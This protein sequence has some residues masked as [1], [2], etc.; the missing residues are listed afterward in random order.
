MSENESSDRDLEQRLRNFYDQTFGQPPDIDKLWQTLAPNLGAQRQPSVR[1]RVRKWLAMPAKLTRARAVVLAMLCLILGLALAFSPAGQAAAH[2]AGNLQPVQGSPSTATPSPLPADSVW[3]IDPENGELNSALLSVDPVSGQILRVL[4]TRYTPDSVLSPDYKRLY[5]VDTYYTRGN[6]GDSISALTVYDAESGMILHD[7]IQVPERLMYKMYPTFRTLFISP[8]GST[9]YLL[10]Y[11]KNGDNNAVR[12]VALDTVR[13][14]QLWE[15]TLT[16]CDT[17]Q[18]LSDNVKPIVYAICPEGK[19]VALG[20]GTG[21]VQSTLKIPSK[22]GQ[23]VNVIASVE[24]RK[25]LIVATADGHLYGLEMSGDHQNLVSDH[26]I[27]FPPNT[28]LIPGTTAFSPQG[29]TLYVGLR[30]SLNENGASIIAAYDIVNGQQ[31]WLAHLSSG[32]LNL[33]SSNDGRWLY[34]VSPDNQS[35]T[36]LDAQTGQVGQVVRPI[37]ESPARI[38]NGQ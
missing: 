26:S 16:S 35:L 10:K 36:V 25:Q 17:P 2:I 13:F 34:A 8:D 22:S 38:V 33:E 15:V 4:S 18:L 11:D 20:A 19:V 9:L 31:R 3:L 30:S 32:A 21:L 6:R 5:V 27:Q 28:F 1:Q 7:D 23:S 37:G 12:V 14:A 29:N 24:N